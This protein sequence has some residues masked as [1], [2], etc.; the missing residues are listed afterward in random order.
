MKRSLKQLIMAAGPSMPRPVVKA[1]NN[2]TSYL[3]LGQQAKEQHFGRPR[4]FPTREDLFAFAIEQIG[5]R[6]LLYLEFGVSDGGTFRYWVDAVRTPSARFV[7]FDSFEGLPVKWNRENPRG[8]F[9][10]GGSVPEIEDERAEFVKGWLSDTLPTYRAPEHE[11]LFVNVDVDLYSSTATCLTHVEGLLK[12]GSYIYFDEY[13]DR[14]NE[15]RAFDE[16]LDRTGMRFQA[17]AAVDN[18]WQWLFRR[19]A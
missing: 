12:I 16:F 1:L 14:C 10:T 3:E 5:S 19:V 9:S 13:N 7:G 8:K 18:M 6:Q 15:M 2:L 4:L 11:L 17:V